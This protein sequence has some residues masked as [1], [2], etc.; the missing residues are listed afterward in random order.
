MI[1][2]VHDPQCSIQRDQAPCTD[3]HDSDH[4]PEP[5]H[6]HDTDHDPEPDHEPDLDPDHDIGLNG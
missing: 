4:D 5:D 2:R 3:D 6:D 1:T